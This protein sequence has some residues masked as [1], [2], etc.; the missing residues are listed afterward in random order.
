MSACVHSGERCWPCQTDS[1]YDRPTDHV[2]FDDEDIAYAEQ[3]GHPAP[4]GQCG[5]AY[6]GWPALDRLVP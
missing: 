5:C 6:C 2:W 3:N 1:C 4:T